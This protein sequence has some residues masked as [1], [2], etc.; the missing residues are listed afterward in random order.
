M[1]WGMTLFNDVNQV[2]CSSCIYELVP[3]S[4]TQISDLE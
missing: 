1:G 3:A 2:G 4:G